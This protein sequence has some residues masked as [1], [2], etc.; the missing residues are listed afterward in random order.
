MST[1]WSPRA[2]PLAIEEKDP[3]RIHTYT[4][5]ATDLKEISRYALSRDV[6]SE[7]R[8]LLHTQCMYFIDDI[9]E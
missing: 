6:V 3:L 8:F 5:F 1:G 7:Q 9:R 4:T 2:S